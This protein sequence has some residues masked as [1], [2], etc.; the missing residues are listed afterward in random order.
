MLY[1]L[2]ITQR[3][4]VM[5]KQIVEL[6]FREGKRGQEK[7]DQE[8][9]VKGPFAYF[10]DRGGKYPWNVTHVPSGYRVTNARSQA[11]AKWCIEQLMSLIEIPWQSTDDKAIVAAVEGNAAL[12]E[13]LYQIIRAA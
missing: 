1:Y 7:K 13:K 5:R 12:K 10:R 6:A 9:Y 3:E 11:S 4:V 2:S 8:A